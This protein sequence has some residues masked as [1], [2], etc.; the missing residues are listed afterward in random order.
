[1]NHKVLKLFQM[2]KDFNSTLLLSCAC[3]F[4]NT[5]TAWRAALKLGHVESRSLKDRLHNTRLLH[6]QDLAHSFK[7]IPFQGPVSKKIHI[8][9]N[10]I[11]KPLSVPHYY[12]RQ[13]SYQHTGRVIPGALSVSQQV[14]SFLWD[15]CWA[16]YALL[17]KFLSFFKR[18]YHLEYQIHHNPPPG[19]F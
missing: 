14:Q 18:L 1:M 8:L 13:P 15:K 11:N 16:S 9:W 4:F 19:G 12:H 5:S 6:W 2:I 17:P 3:V 7:P 10:N